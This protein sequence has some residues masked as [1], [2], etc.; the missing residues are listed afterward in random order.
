MK[1]TARVSH[2]G[3]DWHRRAGS[4]RRSAL[5]PGLGGGHSPPYK[6]TGD[7]AP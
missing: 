2:V 7:E 4:A 3:L 1:M 6:A 5:G